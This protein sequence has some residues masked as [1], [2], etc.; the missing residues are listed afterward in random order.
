MGSENGE[1]K[2]YR[3]AID[4]MAGQLR[5]GGMDGNRARERALAAARRK[6][7]KLAEQG[8]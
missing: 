5:D 4:R 7:R 2:G 1:R 8:Q 3:E 6:D